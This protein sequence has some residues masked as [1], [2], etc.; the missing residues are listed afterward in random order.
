MNPAGVVL[1]LFGVWIV[2]QVTAGDALHRLR[3]L[4]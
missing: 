1:A 2:T 3:L 4:S